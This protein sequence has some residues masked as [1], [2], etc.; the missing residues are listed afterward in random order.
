MR[1]TYS[2]RSP[3][4][5]LGHPLHEPER[6]ALL[7][8]STRNRH[9]E[10][11]SALGSGVQC[12]NISGN[13]LPIGWGER[14]VRSIRS[15]LKSTWNKPIPEHVKRNVFMKTVETCRSS[16]CGSHNAV[17]QRGAEEAF[18]LTELVVVLVVLGAMFTLLLSALGATR[19]ASRA[20]QCMHN[21]QQL[22]RA[23][24]MYAADNGDLLPPNPDDGNS[25]FGHNW[26]PGIVAGSGN[27]TSWPTPSVFQDERRFL[28]LPYV[29]TIKVLKCPAD[30]RVGRFQD[31]TTGPAPRT[32]S[33]NAPV[34]TAC[35]SWKQGGS[36]TG[37][38][39]STT[40]A[41]HLTGT[42]NDSVY[43]RYNKLTAITQPAPAQLWVFLDESAVL[44]N[45]GSFGFRMTDSRW[46]DA[47][48]AYHDGAGCF[49]F[50]D[51]HVEI[52]PWKSAQTGNRVGLITP[53]TAEEEDYL[54][55]KARTSALS[56]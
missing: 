20:I 4:P 41:P 3:H 5:S 7:R 39:D 1:L 40:R 35:I 25:R 19:P 9:A 8:Q 21:A 27:L 15:N 28:L 43:N 37:V 31:N 51:G 56:Q 16:R 55:M 42:A 45:D 23:T 10:Q 52:H 54:W 14:Q 50:A 18:T 48:G 44:L 29:Q 47:P 6:G 12:A 46:V 2:K 53:G 49:S 17:A 36:H 26:V 13:S 32:F 38:P 30:Y 22:M 34:G 11:C 24:Q 33:M